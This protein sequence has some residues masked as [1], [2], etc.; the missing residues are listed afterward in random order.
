MR[1]ETQDFDLKLSSPLQPGH[2]FLSLVYAR[3]RRQFIPQGAINEDLIVIVFVDLF[4]IMSAPLPPLFLKQT[5]AYAK[6]IIPITGI[7]KISVFITHHRESELPCSLSFTP[8]TLF[9]RPKA[10]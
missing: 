3:Q 9:S 10:R 6:R 1:H 5:C 4:D 2:A 7:I 8:K